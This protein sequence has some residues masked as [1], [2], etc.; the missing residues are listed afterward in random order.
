MALAA[1]SVSPMHLYI[2][3]AIS[4]I[5]TGIGV[6]I[7]TY[8]ANRYIITHSQK[9]EKQFEERITQMQKRIDSLKNFKKPIK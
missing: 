2:G 7:G 3:M 5:F 1:T 8:I 6:A 4:G 9:V